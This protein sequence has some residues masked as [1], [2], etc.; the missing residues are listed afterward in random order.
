MAS[1]VNRGPYQ[2]QVTVRRKG[3]PRQTKTFETEREAK[4]WAKLVEAD[5]LRGVFKDRREVENMTLGELLLTRP[6]NTFTTQHTQRP[7]A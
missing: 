4:D 3:H 5:M 1:I 7:G 2:F 6:L